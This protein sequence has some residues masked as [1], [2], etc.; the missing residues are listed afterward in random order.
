MDTIEYVRALLVCAGGRQTEAAGD[1]Q[2]GN[3]V[4]AEAPGGSCASYV[5]RLSRSQ[6]SFGLWLDQ[7]GDKEHS[8]VA[9]VALA[10]KMTPIAWAVLTT[11]Q[12]YRAVT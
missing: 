9:V 10:N 7:L 11:G 8:N 1:Q 2:A 4:R 12:Q 3:S 5:A 6:H